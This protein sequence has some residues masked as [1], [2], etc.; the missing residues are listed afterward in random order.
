MERER[1]PPGIL[2]RL[3]RY[4]LVTLVLVY[5]GICLLVFAFQRNLL[6]HPTIRS[7][8]EVDQLAGALE[9]ISV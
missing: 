3:L 8:A 1:K 7:A 2:F 4:L 9:E 6:Y 5:A